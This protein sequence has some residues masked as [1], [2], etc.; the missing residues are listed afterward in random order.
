MALAGFEE[1]FEEDLRLTTIDG[2][3]RQKIQ[4]YRE[5]HRK[6]VT[7]DTDAYYAS[8]EKAAMTVQ[9]HVRGHFSRVRSSAT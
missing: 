2:E 6:H 8:L 5:S 1:D 4:S 9:K 7:A 3:A